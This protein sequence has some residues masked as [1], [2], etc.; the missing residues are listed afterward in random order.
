MTL[1]RRSPLPVGRYW[2]DIFQKQAVDWDNW[3]S[4]KLKDGSV[5]IVKLEHFRE[6]PL[7]DGS[8]LPDI[9][10]PNAGR[11]AARTWVLFDVLKSV[12]WPATKLGFPTIAGNV[13]SSSETAQNPPGPSPVQEIGDAV[14]EAAE[15]AAK[16]LKTG[17]W[18]AG[19]VAGIYIFRK[20]IFK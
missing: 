18:I 14:S 8:W 9:F 3:V 16:H 19:V 6:D 2:Q 1:E 4:P 7:H 13:Q 17:L 20:E 11:I 10:D 12:D 5:A 15:A